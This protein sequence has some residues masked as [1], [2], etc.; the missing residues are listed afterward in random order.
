LI[1]EHAEGRVANTPWAGYWWPY[2]DGGTSAASAAYDRA[3]GGSRPSS[4]SSSS[5]ELANHGPGFPGLEQWYGHCNGWSAA[6]VLYKEPRTAVSTDGESFSVAEQKALLTEIGMEVNAD[7]F[8]T[9]DN[10]NDPS[11]ATFNDIAPDVFFLVLTN[12]VGNGLGVVMDRYTGDQ[13]WN[14]PIAGY[15][16]EPITPADSL[17]PAPGSPNVFRVSVTTK[18]WWSRDDVPGGTL[19]EP[20]TFE[21][22]ESFASRT[23]RYELW[24]SAPPVFDAQGKLRSA[25]NVVVARPGNTAVGGAWRNSG[26]DVYDSHP[27]YIWVPHSVTE[28]TGYSNP[29]LEIPWVESKFGGA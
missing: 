9:R 16:I 7:F 17:G 11:S 13:V 27:D 4:S 22:G 3:R 12:Y 21:D 26:M 18:V 5:W 2:G 1:Q 6:A 24:L 23:L 10:G 20:F 15:R 29:R 25:G 28:S 19:T 8:G 14:Q